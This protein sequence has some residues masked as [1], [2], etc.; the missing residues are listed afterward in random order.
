LSVDRDLWYPFAHQSE[1]CL[2]VNLH[3]M[4]RIL[5]ITLAKRKRQPSPWPQKQ[6]TMLIQPG[7]EGRR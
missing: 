4:C 6:H 7:I 5:N 2:A 3:N 1:G